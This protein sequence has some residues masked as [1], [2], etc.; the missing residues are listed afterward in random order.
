MSVGTGITSLIVTMVLLTSAVSV[1]ATPVL[2]QVTDQ[3]SYQVDSFSYDPQQ[4]IAGQP[5]TLYVDI[6]AV[7][8]SGQTPAPNLQPVY[9]TLLTPS[10]NLLAQ[11]GPLTT[12]PNGR[13]SALYTF[14]REA[15]SVTYTVRFSTPS[16]GLATI[17]TI[18]VIAA[19]TPTAQQPT[20][21]PQATVA[22]STPTPAPQA[23]TVINIY[24]PPTTVINNVIPGT[25]TQG[26]NNKWGCPEVT[27]KNPGP[28]KLRTTILDFAKNPEDNTAHYNEQVGIAKAD[29]WT[30]TD[31]GEKTFSDASKDYRYSRFTKGTSTLLLAA[32]GNNST[33]KNYDIPG[34]LL[35]TEKD[36][37]V[38]SSNSLGSFLGVPGFEAVYAVAGLVAVAYL[39]MRRRQ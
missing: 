18:T 15:T 38:S 17:R 37:A 35:I 32:Q 5:T 20:A 14:P 16:G 31:H 29:G 3:P 11:L 12:G 19:T 6:V 25:V 34:D 2:A 30:L 33:E 10:N 28:D 27:V 13:A 36:E 1:L 23:T 7:T 26:T 4:P 9:I 21:T 8:Q 22:K 39:V 24:V